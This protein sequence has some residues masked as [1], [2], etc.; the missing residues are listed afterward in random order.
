MRQSL[1]GVAIIASLGCGSA[2]GQMVTI[3]SPL[4]SNGTSFYEHSHIGWSVQNPH[5]FMRFNGGAAN[6]PF[7]GFQPAA[8]LQGG[9]AV[10]N[11]QFNFGFGQGASI[12]STSTVPVLTVTNG[13]PGAM[14][15]GRS[16]P[17]VTGLVPVVGGGFANVP[18]MGPLQTRI[19]TGELRTSRNRGGLELDDVPPAPLPEPAVRPAQE[20]APVPGPAERPATIGLSASDY[21]QRGEAA[22]KDG[23]PG[24]AMIYYQLAATKGDAVIKARAAQRLAGLK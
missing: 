22:E 7:G 12:I 13:Y 15:I 1:L 9:L 10:G 2:L 24:V 11:S 17:F 20:A 14:F 21:L 6:P 18:P 8:G 3:Q 16:R 19:A 5:Y 4:R 23:R